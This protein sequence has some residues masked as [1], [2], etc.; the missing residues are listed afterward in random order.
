MN[1]NNRVEPFNHPAISCFYFSAIKLQ[2]VY[3]SLIKCL[4]FIDKGIFFHKFVLVSWSYFRIERSRLFNFYP[5]N[6]YSF[7]CWLGRFDVIF[8][9]HKY[10]SWS[11]NITLTPSTLIQT[12]KLFF[13]FSSIAIETSQLRENPL[14]GDLITV[15]EKAEAVQPQGA[16]F[17]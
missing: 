13:F 17:C 12:F 16:I 14:L 6:A 4:F 1:G 15:G 9:R 5:Y 2:S 11:L 10:S 8:Q 3:F 7:G